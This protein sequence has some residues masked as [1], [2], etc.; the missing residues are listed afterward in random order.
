[1]LVQLN[2]CVVVCGSDL[3]R[4]NSGH[5]CLSSSICLNMSVVG[6]IVCSE[7]GQGTTGYSGKCCFGVMYGEWYDVCDLVVLSIVEVCADYGG[8]NF[9]HVSLNFGVVYSVGVLCQCLWCS[10][11]CMFLMSGCY[12]FFFVR[13]VPL[14]LVCVFVV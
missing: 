8:V 5:G 6:D 11:C 7:L 12:N 9:F 10:L 14:W 2:K 13:G 3:Q 4:G 1:M